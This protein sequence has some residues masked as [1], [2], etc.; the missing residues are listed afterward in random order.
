MGGRGSGGQHSAYISFAQAVRMI[1]HGDDDRTREV[2][3][4]WVER[5]PV[6]LARVRFL[7]GAPPERYDDPSF[8]KRDW[9]VPA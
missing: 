2:R 3:P 8:R 7:E 4:Y 5:R 6:T 9:V 1:L